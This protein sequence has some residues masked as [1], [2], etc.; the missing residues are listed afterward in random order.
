MVD[1]GPDLPAT[2]Y[3]TTL[4]GV[5]DSAGRFA[6]RKRLSHDPVAVP[7]CLVAHPRLAEVA[8]GA[9]SRPAP[10]SRSA[11]VPARAAAW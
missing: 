2:G 1:P 9:A 6:L 4:R 5:A 3:R 11:S 7:G 8:A 10:R